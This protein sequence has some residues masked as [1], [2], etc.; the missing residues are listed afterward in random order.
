MRMPPDLNGHGG[1][2][3]A[4]HLVE[5]LRRHGDIH[6]VLMFRDQD[7]DCVTTSL[8]PLAG[9]G[10]T[11]TRITLPDW[12]TAAEARLGVIHPRLWDLMRVRCIEAPRFSRAV[13]RR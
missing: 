3:R 13:L 6:F 2:Q 4:W 1:S 8:A 11:I 9:R 10:A 12:Q 7:T 5:A